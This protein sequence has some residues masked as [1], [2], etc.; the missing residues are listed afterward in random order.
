MNFNFDKGV[1]MFENIQYTFVESSGKAGVKVL[2]TNGAY[3]SVSL[4]FVVHNGSAI[5]GSEFDIT[6]NTV[7][8]PPNEVRI[9]ITEVFFSISKLL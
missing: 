8:F 5:Q 4:D 3:G 7:E 9:L 2:R 6:S 1:F